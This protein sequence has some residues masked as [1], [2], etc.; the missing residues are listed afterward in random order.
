LT[1]KKTIVNWNVN[2]VN[3]IAVSPTDSEQDNELDTRPI[4]K[5]KKSKSS[6]TKDNDNVKAKKEKSTSTKKVKKE[7]PKKQ[8]KEKKEKKNK[9]IIGDTAKKPSIT[10]ENKHQS[11]PFEGLDKTK[12][13]NM[14]R[15]ALKQH[16]RMLQNGSNAL[17]SV[18]VVQTQQQ[19]QQPVEDYAVHELHVEKL[20]ITSN[21]NEPSAK[22]LKKNK[23]KKKNHLKG[24]KAENRSHVFYQQENSIETNP[25]TIAME[26]DD[27]NEMSLNSGTVAMQ[28]AESNAMIIDGNANSGT[29]PNLYGRAFVTSSESEPRY[30]GHRGPER[31][32][33]IHRVPT[34]FYAK[35]PIEDNLSELAPPIPQTTIT[36]TTTTT[37]ATAITEPLTDEPVNYDN[38]PI[39]DFESNIPA[40]G[41]Q[42]A[43]KVNICI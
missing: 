8:K 7:E 37:T 42:L 39:A 32:Y 12:K 3:L 13:R 28:P 21:N 14:R 6:I 38:L 4:K 26:V 22:L 36:T 27:S 17:A 31:K 30:K 18:S 23:N 40:I 2:K 20:N 43:I 11:V 5:T 34:L 9:E 25:D 35:K 19:P 33:P 1:T 41:D 24:S 10:K 16:H 15:K 29:Q